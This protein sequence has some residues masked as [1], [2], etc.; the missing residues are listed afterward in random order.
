MKIPAVA[1]GTWKLD[2]AHAA[3]CVARA[4]GDGYRM[5]DTAQRYH[6]E[7]GVGQGVLNSGVEREEVLIASKLRGGDQGLEQARRAFFATL[8]N[9]GLDYIDLYHIHWPLP[10]LGL[11]L[12]SYEAL[13]QLREE[14][15]IKNIGVCNFPIAHLQ[16]IREEFGEYPAV[17]QFEVH[18]GFAQ[19]DLVNFCLENDI[20][21]QGWGVIGRGKGLLEHPEVK[22]VAAEHSCSPA[23]VCIAWACARGISS[24]AKS[25]NPDRWKDNLSAPRINLSENNMRALDQISVGRLGKDPEVDEEY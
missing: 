24:V 19:I 12:E 15:F 4:I 25:A 16:K 13:M 5:V 11:Y 2:D 10:R 22:K 18:P 1:Y 3:T 21:P 17:N 20:A 14:G 7:Y 6:N 23:A 8:R 9:L